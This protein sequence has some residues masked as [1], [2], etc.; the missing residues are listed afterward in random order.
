[1]GVGAPPE[2]VSEAV[3]RWDEAQGH[4]RSFVRAYERGERAYRGILSPNADAA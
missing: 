2:Y 1:M 3:K 4:H